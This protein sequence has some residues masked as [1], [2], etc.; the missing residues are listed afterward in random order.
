MYQLG[1]PDESGPAGSL[2]PTLSEHFS[3]VR[4]Q[5]ELL[6]EPLA[7]EDYVIQ[8][9]PDASPAKWHLAHT[10][11]F[12]ETFLL[13]PEMREY[14]AFDPQFSYLFNSYYLAVGRRHTRSERGLISRP[15]VAEIFHYRTYVNQHMLQFSAE[16]EASSEDRRDRLLPLIELGL[17]HEQQHQ[18]LILTDLKHLFWSN[19]LLPAYKKQ[20]SADRSGER[21]AASSWLDFGGGLFDAGHSASGFCFD[22]ETPQHHV[23]LR[24]FSLRSAPVTNREYLE[25]IGDGG[26]QRP[27]LWLSLGAD[28]LAKQKW[29]SPLYW[30]HD[31]RDWLQF[32]LSGVK[33]LDLD[34]PVCHVSFFEADAFARWAGAR[35]PTEFEWELAA[36]SSPIAGNF[37]E[38]GFFH[39]LPRSE[40]RDASRPEQLFGDVWEWTSSPYIGY[41]GY[42][43]V[44]GALGEYNGK[45]MCNQYVLRGGSCATPITHIRPTYRNFFSPDA[46]WQFGGFRLAADSD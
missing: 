2:G 3:A 28:C 25:F 26:Y 34:E 8:S 17:N 1:E 22:N 23:F 10:S 24:P 4:E 20:L 18:E 27:E 30:F 21:N 15:T 33:P 7:V 6:C 44:T 40:L 32:T 35:L 31:G 13:A 19:P 38:T 46:R 42:V 41:P 11:W 39:P 5:T 37:L 16:L 12:F 29:E 36:I 9:M 45:F 14:R 43:P